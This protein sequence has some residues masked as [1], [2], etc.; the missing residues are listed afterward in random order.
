MSKFKRTIAV[1]LA[2]VLCF[3]MS[4]SF[5]ASETDDR[6]RYGER[7]VVTVLDTAYRTETVIPRGQPEGGMQFPTGGGLY[8]NTSGGPTVSVSVGVD[9]GNVNVS[10]SMGLAGKSS[11]IGGVFLTAPNTSDYFIAK[12]D[13]TFKIEYKKVDVYKYNIYDRTYY[14]SVPTLFSQSA[15]LEA[16]E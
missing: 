3:S 15:Y 1:L 14:V 10:M 12:I 8:V 11:L 16:V 6:L 9:W 4:D 5:F 13:K 7:E 2:F